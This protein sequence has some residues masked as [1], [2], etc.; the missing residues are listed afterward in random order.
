MIEETL[1]IS[2]K[3]DE[4]FIC[5]PSA[6]ALPCGVLADGC[7]GIREGSGTW[8]AGSAPSAIS[9]CCP[10]SITRRSRHDFGPSVI[11]DGSAERDR[12]RAVRTKMTIPRS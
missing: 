1:D 10:T 3:L 2:T 6:A 7:A 5:R 11:E 9:C 8:R 4:T 12:M